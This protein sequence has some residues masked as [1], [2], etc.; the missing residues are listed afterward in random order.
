MTNALVQFVDVTKRFKDAEAVSGISLSIAEGEFMTLLGPSGCGKTT[1]LRMLA[2]FEQVS[3]GDILIG[4]VS[5]VGVPPYK[6]PIGMVFQNLALFPHLTVAENIAFG[7]K[8]RGA[9]STDI[10]RDIKSSLELVGLATYGD[11]RIGQLSGGQRQRV[12][13][14]RSLVLKPKVLLLDEP[15]SALDLKLRRQMQLEL[16]EIQQR[17]GTTFVFVTHDQEEALAMSDRI[18]VMSAGRVEQLD[19]AENVYHHPATAF[20][21]GFIGETNF[22]KGNVVASRPGTVTVRLEGFDIDVG[23]PSRASFDNGASVAAC[24]RPEALALGAAAAQAPLRFDATVRSQHYSGS[25]RRYDLMLGSRKMIARVASDSP[26]IADTSIG[27][28]LSIGLTPE[29]MTLVPLAAGS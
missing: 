26:L 6:R 10:E 16:K 18:A 14:A 25:T 11:R 24:I 20:V 29:K 5:M 13:L 22:I 1:L 12:A 2:G 21:A 9:A 4:G 7:L 28:V 27:S 3:S 8:V 17:V 19:T 23:I 15:L